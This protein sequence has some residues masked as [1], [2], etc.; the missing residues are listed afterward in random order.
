MFFKLPAQFPLAFLAI[1]ST[2]PSSLASS[3]SFPLHPEFNLLQFPWCPHSLLLILTLIK[4]LITASK[5]DGHGKNKVFPYLPSLFPFFFLS[6]FF[7]FFLCIWLHQV[8]V[9]TCRFLGEASGS[10]SL[11]RDWTHAP[12]KGTQSLIHWTLRQVS[13]LLVL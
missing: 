9:V 13:S 5:G 1:F 8:L 2:C 3:L 4:S 6:S 7:L 10:S 12:E 11:T